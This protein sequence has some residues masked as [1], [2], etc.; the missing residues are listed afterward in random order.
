MSKCPTIPIISSV[1]IPL[2]VL[3]GVTCLTNNSGLSHKNL[4]AVA[5]VI[6]T[7]N[8]TFAL[9]IW[10][11]SGHLDSPRHLL[12]SSAVPHTRISSQLCT[13]NVWRSQSNS[14]KLST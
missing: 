6:T 9:M 4:G 8:L 14:N 7:I 2:C 5:L 10:K 1:S 3:I 13:V 11:L 12:V